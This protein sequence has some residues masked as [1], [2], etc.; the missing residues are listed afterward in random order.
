MRALQVT[1]LDGA[2]GLEVTEVPEPSAG[3]GI[4][5][6]AVSAAVTFPELLLSQGRY[7][8]SPEVPF[9]L[10]SD[11]AGVVISAPDGSGFE[12]GDRVMALTDAAIAER[13]VA[14]V[15][16]VF[17]IPD[18]LG[19]DEAAGF[20]LNFHTAHTALHRRGRLRPGETVLVQ[21]AAGGVGTAAIQLA[22]AAGAHVLAVVSSNEKAA[23]AWEAGADEVVLLDDGWLGS[24]RERTSGRGV[25]LVVD[26]VGGDRFDDSLRCLAPEGR[27][28]V[29]GFASGRIPQLKVNRLLLR[30]VDVVGVYASIDRATAEA[31]AQLVEQ[32][33]RPLVGEIYPLERGAEAV[34][35]LAERRAVKKGV[36][37]IGA[38]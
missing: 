15:E 33:L 29:V 19:F 14:P 17:A 7:H 2:D 26:P 30:G 13:V 36:I 24:V 16:R 10:G 4:L 3:D 27:L 22:K 9:V 32:G 25:D 20:V 31:L 23:V 28:L 6:E 38:A 11:V 35:A 8:V 1:R 21:G 37:R 34:R 18:S 5:I 12:V